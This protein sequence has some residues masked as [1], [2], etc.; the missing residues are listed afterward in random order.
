SIDAAVLSALP[1]V[2]ARRLVLRF[3][4]ETAPDAHLSA[5]HLEA[6][7]RLAATDNPVGVLDLP[8]LSVSK[9]SGRLDFSPGVRQPPD[10]GVSWPVRDLEVPGLVVLPEAGVEIEARAMK[11]SDGLDAGGLHE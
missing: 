5:Q 4:S 2:L 7:C 1:A 10:I 6:V 9:E 3:A 11:A 8:G